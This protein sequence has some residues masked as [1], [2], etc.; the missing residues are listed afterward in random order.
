MVSSLLLVVR[1]RGCTAA[2][3]WGAQV[4]I[5]HHRNPF[6]GLCPHPVEYRDNEF[7]YDNNYCFTVRGQ[8]ISAAAAPP[9][10]AV[11]SAAESAKAADDA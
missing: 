3:R 1:C 7:Y 6:R 5:P 8:A 2:S 4:V 10:A 11:P 9:A